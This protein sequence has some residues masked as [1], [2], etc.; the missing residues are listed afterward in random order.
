[1]TRGT[2]GRHRQRAGQRAGGSGPFRLKS[3]RCVP[4][5]SLAAWRPLGPH[6]TPSTIDTPPSSPALAPSARRDSSSASLCKLHRR[7]VGPPRPQTPAPAQPTAPST[8]DK[9]PGQQLARL[10]SARTPPGARQ[11]SMARSSS[12][13]GSERRRDDPAAVDARGEARGLRRR[14]R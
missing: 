6:K 14:R 13:T 4:A 1:M 10:P 5:S 3:Q 9:E 8:Q 7:C 11:D 2:A 12:T